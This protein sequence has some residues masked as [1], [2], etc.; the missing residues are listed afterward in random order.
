MAY[1][2]FTIETVN[3]IDNIRY[4]NIQNYLETASAVK[5]IKLMVQRKKIFEALD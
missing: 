5:L 3:R 1:D 2:E 4:P